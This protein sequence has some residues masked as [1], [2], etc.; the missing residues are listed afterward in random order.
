MSSN[1][2]EV[3]QSGESA[4]NGL[5]AGVNAAVA[6]EQYEIQAAAVMAMKRPRNEHEAMVKLI[7]VY[8]RPKAAETATYFFERAGKQ[9]SGP[10]VKLTRQAVRCWGNIRAGFVTVSI[11]DKYVH[12]RGYALDL[13]TNARFEQEDKF[14][15]KIQRKIKIGNDSVTKWV[16]PDERQLQELINKKGAILERN[17]SLRVL[18]PDLIDDAIEEAAKT[19]QAEAKKTLKANRPDAIKAL[20]KVFAELNVSV[21][22]L[23]K[24]LG[25]AMDLVDDKEYAKLRAICVSIHDGNSTRE[26]VFNLPKPKSAQVDDSVAEDLAKAGKI[27][28]EAKGAALQEGEPI[29]TKDSKVQKS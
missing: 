15:K 14:L 25:H 29:Q 12:L 5:E 3:L 10:T 28:D 9:I 19:L 24:Y 1:D 13:E 6:R 8:Q 11:D 2:V 7:K 17:C 22:M 18:P 16:D 23:E 4:N 26:E 21:E 20:V 27:A